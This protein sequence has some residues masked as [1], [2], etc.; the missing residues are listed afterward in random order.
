M[1]DYVDQVDWATVLQQ[2]TDEVDWAA[3]HEDLMHG[4]FSDWWQSQQG[5]A[6]ELQPSD[7]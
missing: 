4:P 5:A 2:E 7:R 3:V 1:S 6:E